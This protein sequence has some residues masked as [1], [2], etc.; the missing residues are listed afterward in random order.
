MGSWCK[1]VGFRCGSL[2]KGDSDGNL[3]VRRE[4]DEDLM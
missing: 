4:P 2:C 1:E 3:E